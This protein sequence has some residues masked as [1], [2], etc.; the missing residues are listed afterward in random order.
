MASWSRPYR[1]SELES[2]LECMGLCGWAIFSSSQLDF[3]LAIFERWNS[4]AFA[5][6]ILSF[7]WRLRFIYCRI[8]FSMD[9][10]FSKVTRFLNRIF[11]FGNESI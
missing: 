1:A 7:V 5:D 9:W 2:S 6:A 10:V 11:I 3:D 8:N 4:I